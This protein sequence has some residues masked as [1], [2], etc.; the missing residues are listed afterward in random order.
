MS[1]LSFSKIKMHEMDPDVF[2]KGFIAYCGAGISIPA[3][4]CA[5]S[6][7]S[8]TEEILLSFFHSVPAEFQL[9]TD[10]VIQEKLFSPEGVFEVFGTIFGD[11]F[12]KTFESLNV[13]EPNGNHHLIAMLAKKGMLKACFTTNFDIYIER[14]LE[15][16][17][18]KYQVIV[19]NTEFETWLAN[20][21]SEQIAGV[22]QE[23]VDSPF[24]VFK[25]HGTIDR[26]ETIV[27]LASAYKSSNGFSTIKGN[28]LQ[29]LLKKYSCLFLG[30]SGWDF[31]HANYRKFWDDTGNNLK[32][33]FWNRR[34]EETGGPKFPIIFN[35][36]AKK[37]V[38]TEADLPEGWIQTLKMHNVIDTE[39]FGLSVVSSEQQQNSWAE[40]KKKRLSF[41]QSWAEGIPEFTKIATVIAEGNHFSAKFKEMRDKTIKQAQ[42]G[43]TTQSPNPSAQLKMQ[44]LSQKFAKQEITPQEYQAQYQD[45]MLESLMSHLDDDTKSQL[46]TIIHDNTY[47]T[48]T[49]NPQRLSGFVQKIASLRKHYSLDDAIK[50]SLELGEREVQAM[51]KGGNNYLAEMTLTNWLASN[52]APEE[53]KWM[54]T[55]Q[56][57]TDI[58][59]RFLKGNIADQVQFRQEIMRVQQAQVNQQQGLDSPIEKWIDILVEKLAACTTRD[60]FQKGAEAFN[61]AIIGVYARLNATLFHSLEYSALKNAVNVKPPSQGQFQGDMVE[62]QRRQQE[63]V[64]EMQAGKITGA[65]YAQQMQKIQQEIMNN[66]VVPVSNDVPTA[67]P[68][69]ILSNYDKLI[70]RPYLPAFEKLKILFP[71]PHSEPERLMEMAMLALWI[72]G[73][74]MIYMEKSQQYYPIAN[75]GEYPL[76]ETHPSIVQYLYSH[77]LP[78]IEPSLSTMTKRFGQTLCRF[79]VELAEMAH[80]IE[81]CKRATDLSL[82]YESGKVTEQCYMKIPIALAA[83]YSQ[84]EDVENALKYY[85]LG[86]DSLRTQF[87]T[88][89]AD[90]IVYQTAKLLL[91]TDKKQALKVLL[92]GFPEYLGNHPPMK[93]PARDLGL[94]LVDQLIH[95]LGFSSSEDAITQLISK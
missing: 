60:E 68:P 7:W 39:A 47:P 76:I 32:S 26:P 25:I 54:P 48:V 81:L 88:P 64:K 79:T 11:Y 42:A 75:R 71:E 70:R 38:F 90:I 18:V 45:L 52:M 28:V 58:T 78:W 21:S 17:G 3:P 91:P 50:I 24:Y 5:P 34:P 41:L 23:P 85:T 93:F 53:E 31:E 83:F 72:A 80:D 30:Y 8:L 84:A 63:I 16:I 49:N 73:S 92:L 94:K 82:A 33:I 56:K 55:Y 9:P 65:E 6:W 87:I 19:D 4:T 29:A 43:A 10:L 89:F 15:E 46:K 69:E 20:F 67:V 62:I 27:A 95:E 59:D 2:T 74:Q 40:V 77:H 66:T 36:C 22:P 35:S 44:E 57:M 61:I 13:S 37:F 1:N 12:F 86:L 14:A 51:M